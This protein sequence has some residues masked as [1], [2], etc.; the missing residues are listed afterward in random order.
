MKR[1]SMFFNKYAIALDK[2]YTGTAEQL[3]DWGGGTISDWILGGDNTL[4]LTNYL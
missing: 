2:I 1:W 3:W 4:F